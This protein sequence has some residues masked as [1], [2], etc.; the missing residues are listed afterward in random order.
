M[1]RLTRI[2]PL[3]DLTAL[4]ACGSGTVATDPLRVAS[5]TY[6]PVYDDSGLSFSEGLTSE[7]SDGGLVG[8]VG[9]EDGVVRAVRIRQTE[10][11]DVF[12]SINGGPEIVFDTPAASDVWTGDVGS[13][14]ITDAGPER[15]LVDIRFDDG[16]DGD[17]WFG[18]QTAPDNL[19][20]TAIDFR[21]SGTF[22]GAGIDGG[23]QFVV[24]VRFDERTI[25]GS[26]TGEF[27]DFSERSA[28]F[29]ALSG[30]MSG[31]VQDSFLAMSAEL[32]DPAASDR[33]AFLGAFFGGGTGM[34]GGAAG[35]VNGLAVGG[36]FGGEAVVAV[37]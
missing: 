35:T 3:C 25:D 36:A 12:L 6:D 4:S 31:Q 1:P 28:V 10:A 18:I 7:T 34:A 15:G 33:L 27:V 17:G 11:G 2:G 8:L 23:Y 30:A 21:G 37:P 29:G 19:P 16:A 5:E 26:L 32:S 24:T 9:F 14:R 20:D 22:A 13:L